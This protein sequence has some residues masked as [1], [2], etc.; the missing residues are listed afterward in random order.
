MTPVS[1]SVAAFSRPWFL[2]SD[3][4]QELLLLPCRTKQ[5][6][7]RLPVGVC[8]GLFSCC[9]P[10]KCQSLTSHGPDERI[11]AL[12]CVPGHSAIVQAESE[13]VNV[14]AKVLFADL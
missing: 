7:L 3:G 10:R 12:K 5:V 13:F 9:Q 6:S 1:S 2:A 8:S 4:M 11:Q 14:P